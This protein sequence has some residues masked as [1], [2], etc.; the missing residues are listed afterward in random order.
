MKISKPIL[1]TVLGMVVTGLA[2]GLF[3]LLPKDAVPAGAG[4]A[5]YEADGI[6]VGLAVVPTTPKVGEN[7]LIV[8]LTN[9]EGEPITDVAIDAYAEMP[10]MGAMPAMRAPAD[11]EQVGPGRFEGVMDL[12]MR[13]E[14][15]LTLEIENPRGADHRLQFNLA[16][17][18]EGL[19]LAAGA[20]PGG[21]PGTEA[22][23]GPVITVDSRRRQMIGVETGLADIRD[24]VR[25]IRAVGEVTYDERLLSQVVLKFD[26]YIGELFADYVGANVEQG[27]ALFT[28]YSPE[29]LAA[30]QEYLE[31]LRRGSKGS[32]LEAVRQ[33]LLLWDMSP[34]AI[35]ALEETGS[36]E[37]YI[38]IKSPR[39]G[40]VIEL[41]IADGSAAPIGIPLIKIADLSQVWVDAQV[42]EADLSV[43][44]EGMPAK[45]VLPYLP[46]QRYTTEVEYIYPFLAEKSRTG[47]VRMTL[48][49][50]LGDLKPHMYAE[51][52]L[53]VKLDDRLSVP[54]EAVLVAGTSRVVF[55]DLGQ[56]RL[57]PVKI[58]TGRRA[59]GYV[60][61]LEGLSPGDTVVTSGNFLI[62]AETRLKTSI[63]QW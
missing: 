26:G 47:R 35:E 15:P 34:E 1:W 24:L 11:L 18:R 41:N 20:T 19:S 42:Y 10:A 21:G 43:L 31:I 59:Q 13:G 2:V 62:A 30:Q 52:L 46:D 56:G 12:S 54:E 48:D 51:V 7:R 5:L 58:K 8:E 39:T 33:R 63:E 6:S 14:W 61:V 22:V 4:L 25:S 49:N 60:E 9:A 37:P 50:E 57:Q 27:D 28:V 17:D 16:T 3:L 36:P 53:E 29:L 38:A 44:N 23:E 40:T 32:L 45:V 55:R